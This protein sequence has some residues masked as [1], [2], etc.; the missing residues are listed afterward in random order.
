MAHLGCHCND[1]DSR[2]EMMYKPVINI[3]IILKLPPKLRKGKL[4]HECTRVSDSAR[5]INLN[6]FVYRSIQDHG[7]PQL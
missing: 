5:V 2:V 4:I 6:T 1:N 3:R 7:Y